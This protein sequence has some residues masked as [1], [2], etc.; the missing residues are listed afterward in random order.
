MGGIHE[1]MGVSDS[2]EVEV[3]GERVEVDTSSGLE[4]VAVPDPNDPPRENA[5]GEVE[6][7]G[8]VLFVAAPAGSSVEE[9]AALLGDPGE[10]KGPSST[11]WGE[12]SALAFAYREDPETPEP[13]PEGTKGP[14]EDR[15]ADEV[16][17]TP[18]E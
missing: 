16:V 2:V 17:D 18:D 3:N 14:A 8:G 1:T 15:L 13:L 10:I 6:Y 5:D 11:V 9:A 12:D 7:P 4:I